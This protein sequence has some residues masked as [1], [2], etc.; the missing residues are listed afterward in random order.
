MVKQSATG[1]TMRWWLIAF[2]LFLAL[3]AV[4]RAFYDGWYSRAVVAV[5][6]SD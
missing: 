1:E 4:D 2:L 5:I 3:V 6:F